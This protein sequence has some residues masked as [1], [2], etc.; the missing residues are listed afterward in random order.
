MPTD[1][2]AGKVTVNV[3]GRTEPV[4]KREYKREN[5][6]RGLFPA[7][8]EL[9][10]EGA[11]MPTM[12]GHFAVFNEW[13]EIN[14]SWEGRFLERISPGAFEKTFSENTRHMRVLFNH[15]KD[16]SIG[17][18]VLGPIQELRADAKGA[19]YEVP[20]FDTSYNKDLLP[21]LQAGSYGSSFRFKVMRE[22]VERTPE[23]SAHN[24][25]G[26]Q[27]RTILEAKV[28][29]FGPVTFPAYQGATAGVRSLTDEFIL[30]ELDPE[31]IAE[32]LL[33]LTGQNAP[34]LET[35]PEGTSPEHQVMKLAPERRVV[36]RKFNSREDYLEWLSSL[37]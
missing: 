5:L 28:M 19:Y 8:I 7:E 27:E 24:P 17:D 23:R 10:D 30:A 15:G 21:G 29:E 11:G 1:S 18:K 6:V 12:S 31:K 33:R 3:R 4:D 16:P 2:T 34:S 25:E 35:P 20:L 22:D 37:S 9:R 14:S 36:N 32:A 13:T 26:I